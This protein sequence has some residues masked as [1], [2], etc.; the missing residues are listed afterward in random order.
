MKNTLKHLLLK[1]IIP[2]G[3][4]VLILIAIF[5]PETKGDLEE[6]RKIKNSPNS[7]IAQAKR[8]QTALKKEHSQKSKHDKYTHEGESVRCEEIYDESKNHISTNCYDE[9]GKLQGRYTEKYQNQSTKFDGFYTHG[10]KSGPWYEFGEDGS[11]LLEGRYWDGK[12]DGWI[13]TYYN[14]K[15]N[16]KNRISHG[17]VRSKCFFVDGKADGKCKT[18]Y[19]QILTWGPQKH[20]LIRKISNYRNGKKSGM[21]YTFYRNQNLLRKESYENGIIS[22]RIEYFVKYRS[23][24][25]VSYAGSGTTVYDTGSVFKIEKFDEKGMREN[26]TSI[27]KAKNGGIIGSVQYKNGKKDGIEERMASTLDG[28]Q[29]YGMREGGQG[30][31]IPLQL[32]VS[33]PYVTRIW[34]N[35]KLNGRSVVRNIY[36]NQREYEKL[37]ASYKNGKAHGRIYGRGY[38]GRMA[39]SLSTV[40]GKLDGEQVLSRISGEWYAKAIY[41]NGV[42][43]SGEKFGKTDKEFRKSLINNLKQNEFLSYYGADKAGIEMSRFFKFVLPKDKI[44]PEYVPSAEEV[45][46]STDPRSIIEEDMLGHAAD[47]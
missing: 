47:K 43:V 26:G 40:E 37:S 32:R 12:A 45:M 34:K 39:F 1:Y 33:R 11:L 7:L 13:T 4:P 6:Q 16:E 42:F 28:V 5:P 36:A 38:T 17:E 31:K 2:I 29:K 41:R 44:K 10:K 20:N 3:I 46:L 35:G 22:L 27:W 14:I 23:N 15:K 18:Y 8:Q 24:R 25:A 19:P 9:N 21:Q 30:G